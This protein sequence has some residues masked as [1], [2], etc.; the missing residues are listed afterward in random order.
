[1]SEL[2]HQYAGLQVLDIGLVF[3][4]EDE[5]AV[6]V[7]ALHSGRGSGL[8]AQHSKQHNRTQQQQKPLA[9]FHFVVRFAKL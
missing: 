6:E 8:G 2:K 4:E 3:Q 9:L 1:L 7:L 5:N